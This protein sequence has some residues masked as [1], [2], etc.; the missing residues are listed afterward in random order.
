MLLGIPAIAATPAAALSL[1]ANDSPFWSAVAQYE[2]VCEHMRAD[3]QWT[4]EELDANIQALN[5][6]ALRLLRAPAHGA[7]EALALLKICH[8]RLLEAEI[9]EADDERLEHRDTADL[10][11]NFDLQDFAFLEAAIRALGGGNRSP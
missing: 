7:V 9:I 10:D 8:R 4:D 6:A 5:D 3:R 11:G 1:P 2:R